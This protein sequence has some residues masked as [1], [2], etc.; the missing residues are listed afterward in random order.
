MIYREKDF[1]VEEF[2][3]G[4]SQLR[5]LL[6][7]ENGLLMNTLR[8]NYETKLE[9]ILHDN[10][11]VEAFECMWDDVN[12]V[13]DILQWHDELCSLLD[14]NV[15]FAITENP[16]DLDLKQFDNGELLHLK[17]RVNG[18]IL[19]RELDGELIP[20]E[21]KEEDDEESSSSD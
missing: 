4:L 7:D 5:I 16:N 19:Q 8:T 9:R 1:D 18:E 15:K 14:E 17:D 21:R 12:R 3:R 13:Y 10:G 2:N 11:I 6:D 20:L